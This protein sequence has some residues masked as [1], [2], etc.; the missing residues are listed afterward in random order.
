MKKVLIL[1]ILIL[2]IHAE[3]LVESLTEANATK[4]AKCIDDGHRP[5][6]EDE[7][8]LN[9]TA[10]TE[11]RAIDNIS[12]KVIESNIRNDVSVGVEYSPPLKHGDVIDNKENTQIKLQYKF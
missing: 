6:S 4:A 12:V 5:L 9:A 7:Q 8:R 3:S 11:K 2:Q 10:G 1:S